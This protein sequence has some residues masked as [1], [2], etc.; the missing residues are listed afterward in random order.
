M[1]PLFR[2]KRLS[3]LGTPLVR[4]DRR[5]ALLWWTYRWINPL[6]GLRER[7]LRVHNAGVVG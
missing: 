5:C 7:K 3:T 1:A 6:G 2:T 4:K